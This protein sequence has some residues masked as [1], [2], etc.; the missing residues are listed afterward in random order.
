M[1]SAISRKTDKK[2]SPRTSVGSASTATPSRPVPTTKGTA[3]GTPGPGIFSAASTPGVYPVPVPS[4]D[5]TS[6]FGWDCSDEE[7]QLRQFDMDSKY[8]PCMGLTREER[9]KRA[10]TFGKNPP[11]EILTLIHQTTEKMSIF[12]Q[13][14][15]KADR[16]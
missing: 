3:A 6:P 13:R 1:S 5:G 4:A 9:W 12:D 7:Y 2:P 16:M 15:T 10:E 14:L 11:P 8:G